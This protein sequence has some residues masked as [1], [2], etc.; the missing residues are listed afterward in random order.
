MIERYGIFT[1]IVLGESFIKTISAASGFMIN[2]E[3]LLFS[4]FGIGIVFGLW[5]LYFNDSEKSSLKP[6]HWAP[7]V[8]IYAHLP[9]TIG[10]TAFGVASKKLFLSVGEDQLKYNYIVLYCVAIILVGLAIFLIDLATTSRR[11]LWRVGMML[12]FVLLALLGSQLSALT[13]VI[14]AAAVLAG[15]IIADI[16]PTRSESQSPTAESAQS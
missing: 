1:L 13:F 10:L 2:I 15:Q 3:T 12:A 6:A 14:L 16:L 8:W 4:L 7:Y 11:G 9:L 5:W